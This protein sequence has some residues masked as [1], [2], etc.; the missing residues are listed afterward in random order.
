MSESPTNDGNA[1][2]VDHEKKMTTSLLGLLQMRSEAARTVEELYRYWLAELCKWFGRL[3]PAAILDHQG[4]QGYTADQA[5]GGSRFLSA[6]LGRRTSNP[7]LSTE[8]FIDSLDAL[9]GA[10]IAADLQQEISEQ[11]LNAVFSHI[12]AISFNELLMRKAYAT[13]RRGIQIQ[14]NLSQLEDWATRL[15]HDKSWIVGPPIPQ[16]EPLLQAVKL[17]QLAKSATTED[18]PVIIEACPSLNAH[19]IRRILSVYVP[20][21]FEDGPVC[22]SLMRA[23]AL[24][25]QQDEQ[26]NSASD[27]MIPEVRPDSDP[28]QLSIRPRSPSKSEMLPVAY[29]PPT[30]WKLLMLADHF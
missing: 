13:W 29:V 17:L 21:E 28:L 20:D 30:L 19:Q 4:L 3:G 8:V 5:K 26:A 18:I 14:Y 2:V 22:P 9:L 1:I 25:C 11:L 6:L 16:S 15:R 23:M 7:A 27:L 10:M 24:R 12:F